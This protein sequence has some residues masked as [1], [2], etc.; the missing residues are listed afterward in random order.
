M[1]N[2]TNIIFAIILL[3]LTIIATNA[4]NNFADLTSSYRVCPSRFVKTIYDDGPW[5]AFTIQ[6]IGDKSSALVWNWHSEDNSKEFLECSFSTEVAEGIDVGI[7]NDE[8]RGTEDNTYAVVD[9]SKGWNGLG[10]MAP[11]GEAGGKIK[12]GP[13]ID[14]GNGLVGFGTLCEGQKSFV[15]LGYYKGKTSLDI[16]VG[17]D[18]AWWFR[19]SRPFTNG[20]ETFVPE[21]RLRGSEG[22]FHIGFGLGL[23]Y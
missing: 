8:W 14:L 18:N 23:A 4:A 11:M 19:A 20:S 1:K 17:S 13:R 12:V 2:V 6:K 9:I 7:V 22:E 5:S 3:V 16:T 15:G 10:I 21:L